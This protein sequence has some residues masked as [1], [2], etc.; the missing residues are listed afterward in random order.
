MVMLEVSRGCPFNC[1][2]CLPGYAYLP[3]RECR[4]ED[5]AQIL[6]KMPEGIRIGFV[7]CSP[8]SH[9]AFREIIDL[10]RSHGHEVS[11]GSQRAEHPAQL[12]ETDFGGTT[13]TI[14]PETGA[15]GL[16][17]V[18]G[19][20][21]RN[22]SILKAVES[23]TGSVSRIRMYFIYGFPFET[24]EDRAEITNLVAEVR[25]LTDLPVSISINPFIPKP[26]TAFQWSPLAR[27]E[28][29]RK[30][31]EEITNSMRSIPDVEVRFLG[32]REAHIQA[33]L[34][35]GDHRVAE[36]LLHRLDGDG[37]PQAFQK[38]GI[39]INWVFEPVKPGT[40]F[41]WDFINMGFGYT[42]LAREFSL[43]ASTNLARTRVPEKLVESVS[44]QPETSPCC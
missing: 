27:V 29:L 34:T 37:W 12:G 41:E 28:D 5:L 31:R 10:A 2:F 20:S 11:I 13:L 6:Q 44:A 8:D 25:K 35:R 42:R 24:D 32:A 38:A 22:E 14:A 30:W 1:R 15:D 26:W 16:R 17:R 9:P 23:A 19:K 36:A 4:P 40:P 18:I 43:A 21:L 39:D 7:A 3:Y 33:L